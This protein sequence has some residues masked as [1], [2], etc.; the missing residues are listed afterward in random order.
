MMYTWPSLAEER[1]TFWTS[2]RCLGFTTQV[3]KYYFFLDFTSQWRKCSGTI[4][5]SLNTTVK[6]LVK[7]FVLATMKPFLVF[8]ST[9]L[10]IDFRVNGKDFFVRKKIRKKLAIFEFFWQNHLTNLNFLYRSTSFP[11]SSTLL[12]TCVRIRQ[13][14]RAK[15]VVDD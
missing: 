8:L 2:Q 1:M 9:I 11:L 7:N 6:T 3:V 15:F 5:P 13:P 4:S 14:T 12:Y 10:M